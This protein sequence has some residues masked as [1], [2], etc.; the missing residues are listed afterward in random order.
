[1]EKK[2][3][4]EVLSEYGQASHL[5][6][7]G[8]CLYIVGNSISKNGYLTSLEKAGYS[9]EEVQLDVKLCGQVTQRIPHVMLLDLDTSVE[10][11]FHLTAEIKSNPMTYTLPVT[12]ILGDGS[13]GQ[14]IEA[15]RSGADD[16]IA[17][18]VDPEVLR[19]RIDNI[20]KRHFLLQVSNPLTGLPGSLYIEEKISGRIDEGMRFAVCYTDLDNFKAF[21]DKYGYARGDNVLRIL[22]RIL[23]EAVCMFGGPDDFVGHIGGDDFIIVCQ[24]SMVD[25]V[26]SY[27]VETFDMLIPYQ[28]DDDDRI[29]GFIEAENRQH[30]FVRFP[31]MTVSIGVVTNN[32]RDL[33]SFLQISELSAEMKEYAKHFSKIGEIRRSIY[34]IDKR[35]NRTK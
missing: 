22:A 28:Y 1:M 16:Y 25:L 20:L 13:P 4:T 31:M 34:K 17:K 2:Q 12:I 9:I 24:Q 15:L 29:I 8:R 33:T 23:H 14:E 10:E 3:P 6:E 7:T 11:V 27:V 26:C 35:T 18:P 30:E 5:C 21:N 32:K 19:A